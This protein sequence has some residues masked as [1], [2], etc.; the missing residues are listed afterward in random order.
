[1]AM[2]SVCQKL[3]CI[4]QD[5]RN[6]RFMFTIKEVWDRVCSP[7]NHFFNTSSCKRPSTS[8]EKFHLVLTR[9]WCVI[10]YLFFHPINMSSTWRHKFYWFSLI[11]TAFFGHFLIWNYSSLN[12]CNSGTRRDIKKRWTAIFL[13]FAALPNS[14]IK[15]PFHLHFNKSPQIK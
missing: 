13:I 15:K 7:E 10:T 8:S 5:C 9:Y 14:G 3:I 6:N 11:S 1:M 12:P 2:T 4:Y